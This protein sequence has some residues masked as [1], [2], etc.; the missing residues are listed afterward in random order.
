M[1]YFGNAQVGK[2]LDWINKILNNPRWITKEDVLCMARIFN[3]IFHYEEGNVGLIEYEGR[4]AQRYLN[5]RGKL[6]DSE[7]IVVNL[8]YKKLPKVQYNKQLMIAEFKKVREQIVEI[9]KELIESNEGQ[10]RNLLL[11][12][13][14]KI[15]GMSFAKTVLLNFE[16]LKTL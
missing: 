2:A 14:S 8:L 4:N 16:Q 15:N 5:R 1:T 11:W 9:N 13:E 6:Y 12:I 7:K 10:F 3:L